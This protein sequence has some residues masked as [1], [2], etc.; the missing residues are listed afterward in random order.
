MSNVNIDMQ[1]LRAMRLPQT[2]VGNR[3]YSHHSV[4]SGAIVPLCRINLH[5]IG[6]QRAGGSQTY[7]RMKLTLGCWDQGITM[8]A[9]IYKS[10]TN[11]HVDIQNLLAGG[12]GADNYYAVSRGSQ[13]KPNA[14]GWLLMTGG[15][16][17]QATFNAQHTHQTWNE[18][19]TAWA[20]PPLLW[21]SQEAWGIN[22]PHNFS[23]PYKINKLQNGVF[24]ND[25]IDQGSAATN[26]LGIAFYTSSGTLISGPYETQ[27]GDYIELRI[28][29]IPQYT[30]IRSIVHS[31]IEFDDC[32][33]TV[34]FYDSERSITSGT[35]QWETLPV[36]GVTGASDC[37]G[38]DLQ[39]LVF[40]NGHAEVPY[41]SQYDFIW[42]EKR[43]YFNYAKNGDM[44][45]DTRDRMAVVGGEL[46]LSRDGSTW[47]TEPFT[48][49][50]I[51]VGTN[52]STITVLKQRGV[53]PR[54]DWQRVNNWSGDIVAD[55]AD[56]VNF[57]KSATARNIQPILLLYSA[58]QSPEDTIATGGNWPVISL[59]DGSAAGNM[60]V[61]D[62]TNVQA[63]WDTVSDNIYQYALDNGIKVIDWHALSK[64]HKFDNSPGSLMCVGSHYNINGW[65]KVAN[66]ADVIR[67]I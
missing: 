53:T 37:E 1:S 19:G 44:V 9:V 30:G 64:W 50:I 55:V 35:A 21:P 43:G 11:W 52:D 12:C 46:Q 41:G 25:A 10:G 66:Y 17:D 39:S 61:A 59:T 27:S 15:Q 28:T 7:G 8:E 45:Y 13:F 40:I 4:A 65:L 42:T 22:H 34:W 5:G 26:P 62:W 33:H 18:N 23:V 63:V 54:A 47:S 3:K 67:R 58:I 32:N 38:T 49:V 6:F 48:H 29:N 36:V 20:G 16:T 14:E 57:V 24:C 56:V 2:N 60:T 51:G 31:T